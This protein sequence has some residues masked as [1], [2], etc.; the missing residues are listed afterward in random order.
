VSCFHNALVI[1]HIQNG[2]LLGSLFGTISVSF[3]QFEDLIISQEKHQK[4]VRLT[5]KQGKVLSYM[6]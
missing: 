3:G 4:K 2:G 1:D 5:S 6:V